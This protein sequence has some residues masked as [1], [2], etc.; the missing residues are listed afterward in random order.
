MRLTVKKNGLSDEEL[1][2]HLE[3]LLKGLRAGKT[4]RQMAEEY[5]DS[6][7]NLASKQLLRNYRESFDKLMHG[8]F[9]DVMEIVKEST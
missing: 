1:C 8:V 3:S 4:D 6:S 2:D 7:P 9:T 5:A